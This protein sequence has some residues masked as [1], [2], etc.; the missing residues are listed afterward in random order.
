MALHDVGQSTRPVHFSVAMIP[1]TTNFNPVLADRTISEAYFPGADFVEENHRVIMEAEHA[2]VFVPGKDARWQK[3]VGLGYNGEAVSIF[4]TTVAVRSDA[5]E[6]SGRVAVPAISKFIFKMPAT[7]NSPCARCRL[8]PSRRASRN[9]MRSRWTT[10]RHKSFRC[11]SST[12]ESDKRW[13]ENVLRNAALTSSVQPVAGPG[14]HTL[15]I[16][17]VDPGI[18]IDAIAGENNTGENLDYVWPAETRMTRSTITRTVG[19]NLENHSGM[20]FPTQTI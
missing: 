14:L 1:P 11:P 4:P 5:G 17:M 20:V 6:N 10:R 12:S 3:I 2:S 19:V 7:G 9:V 18:V 16:W 8:F 15:K 13:Q